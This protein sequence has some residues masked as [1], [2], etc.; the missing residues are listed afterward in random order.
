MKFFV[1]NHPA[2]SQL[3]MLLKKFERVYWRTPSYNFTRFLVTALCACL[4]G[5][6]YYRA[7]VYCLMCL[8]SRTPSSD[9]K[10][11]PSV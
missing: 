11:P 6:V 1:L 8:Y 7:G 9:L 10:F 2:Q 3:L 4:Y 5:S